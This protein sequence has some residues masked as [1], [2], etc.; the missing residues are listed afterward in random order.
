MKARDYVVLQDC[1][2]TGVAIGWSR[3]HKH[4]DNPT[5]DQIQASIEMCV[6]TTINDYF[7]FEETASD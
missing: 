4:N 6:L 1:V 3:A 5:P 7:T 2:E